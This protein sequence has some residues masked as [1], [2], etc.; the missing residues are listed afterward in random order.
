MIPNDNKTG[1][2][3]FLNSDLKN[4][5][6]L[7]SISRLDTNDVM[8]LTWVICLKN[9]TGKMVVSLLSNPLPGQYKTV[10][11]ELP[12]ATFHASLAK[13]VGRITKQT[14]YSR[15]LIPPGIETI[16]SSSNLMAKSET[17][18]TYA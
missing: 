8:I 3:L 7:T 14:T 11:A 16:G 17:I 12:L 6:R 15:Q 4:K 2:Y 18:L 13:S 10:V 9:Y 1:K 5:K